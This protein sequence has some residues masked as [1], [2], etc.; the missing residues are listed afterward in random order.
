MRRAKLVPVLPC[1]AKA[2][3]GGV[4][5]GSIALPPVRA[6]SRRI[7][8][9]QAQRN[10]V[11]TE[12]RGGRLRQVDLP[13]PPQDPRAQMGWIVIKPA[14]TPAIS[15]SNALCV[16]RVLPARPGGLTKVKAEC[17]DGRAGQ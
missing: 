11:L 8:P 10:F 13:V 16:A 17:R 1:H 15:G 6:R 3:A 9:D 2:E 4:S 5:V 12:A 14:D 7:A